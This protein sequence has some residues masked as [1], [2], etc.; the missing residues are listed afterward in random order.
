MQIRFIL[1]AL[2]LATSYG[3]GAYHTANAIRASEADAAN[4]RVEA[5]RREL[6]AR[7]VVA[8][9]EARREAVAQG[10][11][12]SARDRGISDAKTKTNLD[13]AI[14]AGSLGLLNDAISAANGDADTGAV[15]R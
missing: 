2:A 12:K 1:V 10:K 14:G 5:A 9:E 15:H 3:L 8:I 7:Q 13:C 11:S 6:E 4:A